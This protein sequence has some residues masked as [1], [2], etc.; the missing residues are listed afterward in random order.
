MLRSPVSAL[1][2]TASASEKATLPLH[3][4]DA[5]PAP[6]KR[7]LLHL[8]RMGMQYQMCNTRAPMLTPD[9][10]AEALGC[11][12]PA[13]AST[14]L[15]RGKAT[16]KPVLVIHSAL[17]QLSDKI[18]SQIVGENV[19]RADAEFCQRIAGYDPAC[20]PPLALATRIPLVMDGSL[21]RVARAW[22]SLGAP[23][24]YASLPSIV[25]ARVVSA[26]LVRLEG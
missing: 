22:F 15:Y 4:F 11:S 8:D 19:Q 5:A 13:L 23:G 17:T 18:L 1:E 6:A 26:R 7:I 25:L 12:V 3:D 16:R 14:T 21:A 24:W 20:I 10:L 2:L 9:A